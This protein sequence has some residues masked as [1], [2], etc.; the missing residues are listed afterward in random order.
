LGKPGE[1]DEVQ[2]RRTSGDLGM[3]ER[4]AY[5]EVRSTDIQLIITG[6]VE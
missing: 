3:H 4:E 5:I 6:Q 1:D 2:K